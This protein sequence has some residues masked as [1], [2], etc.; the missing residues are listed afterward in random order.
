MSDACCGGDSEAADNEAPA[1]L[2]DVK[3]IQVSAM[4]GA[5]LA[6]ALVAGSAGAQTLAAVCFA[7]TLV[8]G[9]STFIPQA[10]RGVLRGRLG[11]GT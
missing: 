7:V 5:A 10:V 11:V 3:E 9:G 1:R 6:A 8:V 2:R 4:A